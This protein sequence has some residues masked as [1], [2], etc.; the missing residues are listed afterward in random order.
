MSMHSMILQYGT[1][2]PAEIISLT[3]ISRERSAAICNRQG[4]D[5]L[6]AICAHLGAITDQIRP[7]VSEATVTRAGTD[8]ARNPLFISE[9][10]GFFAIYRGEKEV[11]PTGFEPV[12]FGFGGRR[13]IQLSYGDKG[14]S[15]RAD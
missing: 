7:S 5:F 4:R 8:E 10:A 11:S 15:C 9:I 6:C 14:L 2:I 13:S 1:E 12:T 3:A